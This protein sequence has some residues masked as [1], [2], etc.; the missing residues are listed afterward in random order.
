MQANS[1]GVDQ[2]I[3]RQITVISVL[4]LSM[5]IFYSSEPPGRLV[6]NNSKQPVMNTTEQLVMNTNEQLV[7]N[8]SEQ[9]EQQ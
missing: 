5:Y 8:N 1:P 3:C 7:M 6:M 2:C 9:L 4:H